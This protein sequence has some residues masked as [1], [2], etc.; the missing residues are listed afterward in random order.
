MSNGL[1]AVKNKQIDIHSL[2]AG[3]CW[4][5]KVKRREELLSAGV[6]KVFCHPLDQSSESNLLELANQQSP[7]A[8]HYPLT[9]KH[10]HSLSGEERDIWQITA[11]KIETHQYRNDQGH[12]KNQKSMEFF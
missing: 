12:N 11:E 10:M 3:F 1:P 5:W 8:F 7:P 2:N 6:K 9:L 4:H